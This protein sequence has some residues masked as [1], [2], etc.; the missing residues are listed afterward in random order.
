MPGVT[1]LPGRIVAFLQLG[2][3]PGTSCLQCWS[4]SS[5]TTGKKLNQKAVESWKGSSEGMGW[6]QS[7]LSVVTQIKKGDGM[8]LGE[9]EMPTGCWSV[10]G[11][12]D[13]RAQ[14]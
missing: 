11:T 2:G 12:G 13:R 3:F 8:E 1:S 14:Q 10:S 5:S 7:R 4:E 6:L 9:G